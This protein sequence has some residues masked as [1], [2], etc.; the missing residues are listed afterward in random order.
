[1]IMFCFVRNKQVNTWF[2]FSSI[3]N[4]L[5]VEKK[6]KFITVGERTHFDILHIVSVSLLFPYPKI[7][8]TITGKQMNFIYTECSHL[9]LTS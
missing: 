2:F 7:L 8:F 1:M 6:T 4:I 3:T 5:R 9:G